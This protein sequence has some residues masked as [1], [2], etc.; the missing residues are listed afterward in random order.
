MPLPNPHPAHRLTRPCSC[1]QFFNA[2]LPWVLGVAGLGLS[3]PGV[4]G[5]RGPR[6]EL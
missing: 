2:G 5:S 6:A 1:R 4:R 3:I